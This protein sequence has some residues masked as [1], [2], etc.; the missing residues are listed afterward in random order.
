MTPCRSGA[1][2]DRAN[3]TTTKTTAQRKSRRRKKKKA[4]ATFVAIA[5]PRSRLAPLLQGAIENTK[6]KTPAAC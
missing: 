6:T 5:L 4:Q 3:A 1:S 2:R